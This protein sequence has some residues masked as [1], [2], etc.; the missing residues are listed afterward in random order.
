MKQIM[1][2]LAMLSVGTL[3]W[4]DRRGKMP[5]TGWT[6]RPTWYTQLWVRPTAESRKKCWS[7]Q[8]A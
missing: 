1:F 2:L 3:S 8:S 6:T 4:A 7:T 5:L